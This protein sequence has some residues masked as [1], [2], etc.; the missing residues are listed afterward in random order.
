MIQTSKIVNFR[1]A[2]QI[3]DC[4]YR[5]CETF[6]IGNKVSET[7][8]HISLLEGEILKL[9][10]VVTE[11]VDMKCQRCIA[12]SMFLCAKECNHIKIINKG[13]LPSLL[14]LYVLLAQK[15]SFYNQLDAF[16]VKY[17]DLHSSLQPI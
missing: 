11:Y 14:V 9:L 2:V 17:N 6:N 13:D 1:S 4:S 16:I 15:I 8:V 10:T 5:L 7:T 12:Y 3:G